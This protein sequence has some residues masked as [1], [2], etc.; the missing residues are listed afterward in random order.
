MYVDSPLAREHQRFQNNFRATVKILPPE[1]GFDAKS[2]IIPCR[3]MI[4]Q[5]VPPVFAMTIDNRNIVNILV[6]HFNI[7]WSVIPHSPAGGSDVQ[8]APTETENG[9][10][11][12]L[13]KRG[14][15]EL[16]P[17][18][19]YCRWNAEPWLFCNVVAGYSDTLGNEDH[20]ATYRDRI[21][22]KGPVFLCD[23]EA[24]AL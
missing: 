5:L 17:Q 21:P 22:L 1:I 9:K 4:T 23:P 12:E 24:G 8:S 20:F 11:V 15:I 13:R 16:V 14:C 6:H 19:Y 18:A 10:T 2:A 7:I 3:V